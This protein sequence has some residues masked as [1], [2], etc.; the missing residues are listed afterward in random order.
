MVA[1]DSINWLY[2]AHRKAFFFAASMNTGKRYS[3]AAAD[4]A[5]ICS[6][7]TCTD[8]RRR[9]NRAR[10]LDPSLGNDPVSA[11][12]NMLSSAL[13]RDSTDSLRHARGL[14]VS[15]VTT[16]LSSAA[17]KLGVRSR[18]E[19]VVLA[20][21]LL[22]HMI[23]AEKLHPK[24]DPFHSHAKVASSPSIRA[25]RRSAAARRTRRSFRACRR[26]ARPRMVVVAGPR[27]TSD[28]VAKECERFGFAM[29]PIS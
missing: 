20:R 24:K 3:F 26:T 15:S 8:D 9:K 29:R 13:G 2:V 28:A 14:S 5:A 19:L 23:I 18:A 7:R 11:R 16:F 17:R 12:G 1:L 27:P 21:A 10:C 4:S 6:G 22:K 25:G